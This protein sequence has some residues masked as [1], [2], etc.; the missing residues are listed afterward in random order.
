MII[1]AKRMC[2]SN[3]SKASDYSDIINNVNNKGYDCLMI[4][5]KAFNDEEKEHFFHEMIEITNACEKD[6]F[7]KFPITHFEDMKKLYYVNTKKIIADEDTNVGS[8]VI[9]EGIK[10][11][12]KDLVVNVKDFESL[13]IR[14]NDLSSFDS[15]LI[16]DNDKDI[17]IIDESL[18]DNDAFSFKH[19]LNEKGL[20]TKVLKPLYEWKDLKKNEDGLIPV[21][22]CDHKNEK[23]LMM[24]Y[25][26]EEA[27]NNT[28]KTGLMNYYSRSRKTQW[29]KGET[30]GH[31]QYI[32]SM[33]ADCDLDT[34]L[35]YVSQIGVPCHTGKDTCFFNDVL[36][37]ECSSKNPY[38]ILTDL[39]KV[40]EDRKIDPKEGSYTNYL[41]DKGLDKIL[42]KVGEE[43]C[44][45]L[46][47]SKNEESK[48]IKYEIADFLYH[49]SVLMVEKDITWEEVATELSNR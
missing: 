4:E 7:V 27:Y 43:A 12:G 32:R 9:E 47:A 2:F 25:M 10:R 5:A 42:K 19:I 40:I 21:I 30:S 1:I 45:I 41:F 31:Y 6:V 14:I 16:T 11:Y 44:E 15:A 23:L 18:N 17:Y 49:L 34:L 26:N 20:E 33:K 35:C 48:E 3:D 8:S 24:A 46:I 13:S 28:F 39:Y 38:K 29:V 37:D 36:K 22:V